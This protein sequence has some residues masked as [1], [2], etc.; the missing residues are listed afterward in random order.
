M[1][2]E[3]EGQVPGRR[4]DLAERTARFGEAVI[5]FCL[6][7]ERNRVTKPLIS[8]LVRS[9][10]SIGENNGEAD[11]AGSKKEFRYRISLC[12]REAR[13]TKLWLGTMVAAFPGVREPARSFWK[14]ADELTRFFSS[15]HRS[16]G[17]A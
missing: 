3:L 14:E 17:K 12:R 8:Q 2:N 9:A 10:T 11:E 13:E 4:F 6:D 5:E 1:T 15:I 16:S 7:I